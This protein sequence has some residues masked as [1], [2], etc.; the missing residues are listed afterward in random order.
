MIENGSR[1]SIIVDIEAARQAVRTIEDRHQ[2]ILKL[3]KSVRELHEMF[4]EL[5]RL[6]AT[7]GEMIDN[8]E[9][10]ILQ[11]TE[12]VGQ[13]VDQTAQAVQSKRASR[14]VEN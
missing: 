3:E 10:N 1:V 5:A 4:S 6:V 7:Q 12:F 13:A 11:A 2:D 14:K 9:F 8:I